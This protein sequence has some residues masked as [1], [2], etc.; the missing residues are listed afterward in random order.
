[1]TQSRPVDGS[2]R[3][4][5]LAVFIGRFS[6]PHLGHAEV[7]Q[8]AL[9]IADNVLI[10]I[11]SANAPRRHDYVPFTASERED[12]IRLMFSAEDNRRMRFVH[13]EDQGNMPR[14]TGII[15]AAANALE[16]D[17]KRI[18]LIGHSKDNS[19]FYLKGFPGWDASDVENYMGLSATTYRDQ[20]FSCDFLPNDIRVP[21]L[22]AEVQDWLLNFAKT[23]AYEEMVDE[24]VKCRNDVE[25]Y[26]R[27]DP[28]TGKKVY[29][30]Y[31][32]AD[33]VIIQGDH[34]LMIERG[35]H[36]YRGC[37]AFPGGFVE[38]DEDVV[39]AAI[40]ETVEET[41]LKLPEGVIRRSIVRTET[42]S[43]PF[44]DPRGRVVSFA[45]LF[46]L[47]PVIPANASPKDIEKLVA[48]PRVR[49]GD[50]ALR[51][52]WMPIS[53]L[54]RNTTAFDHYMILQRML[55]HL[56]E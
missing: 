27:I 29:G 45:T 28:A 56:P 19:S 21:A 1:M 4:Y 5:G 44:R 10:A 15:R 24:R 47:K 30:P 26:G 32:A 2:S 12:M 18:T 6:P 42:F 34:V 23:A 41:G 39:E 43:S 55:E 38:A 3:L 33:A 52:F 40:R 48:L 51:A 16:S 9:R 49:G 8:Q 46:H 54:D 22:H 13:V 35:G 25:T 37:V 53:D 36:P 31:L 7:V 11:G 17:N 20:F 50:D 14:W